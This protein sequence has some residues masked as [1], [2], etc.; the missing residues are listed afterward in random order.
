MSLEFLQRAP[1]VLAV[2]ALATV[3]GPQSSS[4]HTIPPAPAW[5]RSAGLQFESVNFENAPAQQLSTTQSAAKP[6]TL[7]FVAQSENDAASTQRWVF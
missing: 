7:P 3:A 2:V 4:H 1:L 6:A 5:E